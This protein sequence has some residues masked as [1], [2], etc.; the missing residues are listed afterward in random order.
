[1][2]GWQTSEQFISCGGKNNLYTVT[3][4]LSSKWA[5]RGPEVTPRSRNS[6]VRTVML[7][8]APERKEKVSSPKEG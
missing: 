5:Y 2:N 3:T 4:P 7:L 6:Q 8:G 1:M